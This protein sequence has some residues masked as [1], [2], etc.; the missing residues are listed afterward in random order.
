MIFF[1]N[2]FECHDPHKVQVPVRVI[3]DKGLSGVRFYRSPKFEKETF[4]CRL[5]FRL[6]PLKRELKVRLILD[7]RSNSL[8]A[9]LMS[10]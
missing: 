6:S 7:T 9:I 1:S 2:R 3:D 4:L 5:N 8:A 10:V